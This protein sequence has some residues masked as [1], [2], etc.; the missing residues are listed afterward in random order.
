[1][2]NNIDRPRQP[3][4]SPMGGQWASKPHADAGIELR[5]SGD[6]PDYSVAEEAYTFDNG[7]VLQAEFELTPEDIE[8]DGETINAIVNSGVVGSFRAVPSG[9]G[10]SGFGYRVS[11]GRGWPIAIVNVEDDG[12]SSLGIG[13]RPTFEPT[14]DNMRNAL[15]HAVRDETMTQGII[16]SIGDV[17]ATPS[18]SVLTRDG[19]TH[20]HAGKSS[21]SFRMVD[22]KPQIEEFS[23]DAADGSDDDKWNEIRRRSRAG[24]GRERLQDIVTKSAQNADY[25][26]AEWLR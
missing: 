15:A 22:G 19:V 23:G 16:S 24:F 6:F 13:H 1:M 12:S 14:P 20:L 5:T 9:T 26:A 7:V 21:L 17:K 18:F 3:S 4:G 8:Q 2:S 10:R 25:T 11:D